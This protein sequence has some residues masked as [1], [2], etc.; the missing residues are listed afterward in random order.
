VADLPT[1]RCDQVELRPF[2]TEDSRELAEALND[3]SIR[4]WWT[5][6]ETDDHP[7]D[8]ENDGK[9]FTI[10]VDEKIAGWVGFEND[11][12]PDWRRASVDIFVTADQQNHGIG[13]KALT[14]VLNWLFYEVGHHRVTID[15]AV[16]NKRAIHVYESLGFQP[17]GVMRRYEQGPDGSWHDNLLMD[18]LVEEY[19]P[20]KSAT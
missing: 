18:L 5:P 20:A 7:S 8:F 3:P 19:K 9:A 12:E 4:K 10:W 6:K 1:L 15:P 14:A 17:V 2:T 13:R 16:D 11:F